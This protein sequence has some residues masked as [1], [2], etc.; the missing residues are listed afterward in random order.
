M[1]SANGSPESSDGKARPDAVIRLADI[2]P[3]PSGYRSADVLAFHG[4]D[5]LSLSERVTGDGF[6][7]ALLLNGVPVMLSLCFAAGRANVALVLEGA[8]QREVSGMLGPEGMA[9][10]ITR[11]LGLHQPVDAFIRRFGDDPEVGALLRPNAGLRVPLAATPFEALTWAIT[12]QQISLSAAMSL[13]RRLIFACGRAHAD[14]L[15]CY[16]DAAALLALGAR[17]LQEAGF[18]RSKTDTLLVVADAVLAGGLPLD[19]WLER[20]DEAAIRERLLGVRGIGPWTVSYTLLRGYGWLD[21]SLHGDA[22][23]RRGL[24]I[25]LRLEHAPTAAFCADWL[26]RF[27]PWRALVA[28]HLWRLAA[29]GGN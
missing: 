4:R 13:R 5:P 14:G 17:R 27:S 24:R 7:K 2:V 8:A 6:V 16:P 10:M 26:A 12:G 18:S 3:L 20:F 29:Q 1:S 11:M 19:T 25:L 23:V 28:A 9:R 15:L 21:G 22:A